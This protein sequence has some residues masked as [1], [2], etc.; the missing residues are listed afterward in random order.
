[1]KRHWREYLPALLHALRHPPRFPSGHYY[2]PIPALAE[3]SGFNAQDPKELTGELEGIDLNMLEQLELLEA[4]KEYYQELPFSE[5]PNNECRYHYDNGVYCHA[6][7]VFLFSMIRHLKPRRIIEIGSGLSSALILDTNERFFN[8]SIECTFIDPNLDRFRRSLYEK[9][10]NE[11]VIVESRVQDVELELFD[12]LQENDILFVDSSHVSKF[13]SDVN[14]ILFKILPRL[15]NGVAIHFHDIFFPF[16]YPK[17][18][19]RCGIAWNESYLLRA[20][21]SFN[22]AFKIL[23]FS[24]LVQIEHKELFAKSFPICNRNSGG[25]LWIRKER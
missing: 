13:Q 14:H 19:L 9:D 1:M 22:A 18:W 15:R 2:S 20:F 24:D 25:C 7:G 11:N 10:L 23:L 17:E 8:S 3:V 12:S 5:Q 21:L 6:D 4:F 16:E